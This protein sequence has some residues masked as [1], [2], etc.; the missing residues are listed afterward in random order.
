MMSDTTQVV[1]FGEALVDMLSNRIGDSESGGP[2]TFTKYAGGAP[3]NAAVAVAKLGGKAAFVGA[4][5]QDQFGH[6]LQQNLADAG[7]DIQ[8]IV[9]TDKA[10]TALA[11]V[12]LDEHGERTFEFYRP[13]AADLCFR[14]EDFR[15]ELFKQSGILHICSNSLT[16]M[17]IAQTT[18]YGVQQASKSGWIT[19]F[20]VN[21][22]HNLWPEGKA[23]AN[24]V[25][26]LAQQCQIIKMS[27]EE[28]DYLAQGHKD[29][30]TQLLQ[31]KPE[32]ILIT[33]GARPVQ[34]YT[35]ADQG[36]LSPPKVAMVDATAAGDAFIGGLLSCLSA[37]PMHSNTLTE[38]LSGHELED[39]LYFACCCGAHAASI[40]GAF[41]SLPDP[42]S[43]QPFL[44]QGANHA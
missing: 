13:P 6:F 27:T 9:T 38:W 29:Y 22:R 40:K 8:H 23:D 20:D 28:L 12:S 15:P 39:D 36:Q 14:P 5:G 7:V 21:L 44:N 26:H 34:W 42:D 35:K 43:L 25:N 18:A 11:F 4:L 32:L 19:S 10:K 31:H 30:L 17:A 41:S 37:K 2:E 1:C 24:R 33:D 3:A 16:E